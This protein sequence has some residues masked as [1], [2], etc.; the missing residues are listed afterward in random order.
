[1]K[2]FFL[3]DCFRG[4]VHQCVYK[5]RREEKKNKENN[6][7]YCFSSGAGAVHLEW[8]ADFDGGCGGGR[9]MFIM[10]QRTIEINDGGIG[11][12]A[13]QRRLKWWWWYWYW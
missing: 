6:H 9:M 8:F 5:K 2:G 7:D 13:V 10:V 3:F 11:D 4:S 12:V 1:M